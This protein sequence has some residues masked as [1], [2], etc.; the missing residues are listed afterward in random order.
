MLSL[1]CFISHIFIGCNST[2]APPSILSLTMNST[3]EPGKTLQLVVSDIGGVDKIKIVQL[4]IAPSLSEL[5]PCWIEYSTAMQQFRIR[6]DEGDAF[7][8]A[9]PGSESKVLANSKCTVD[10]TKAKATAAGSTLNISIPLQL[11]DSMQ[12]PQNIFAIAS[13]DRLHSGWKTVGVWAAR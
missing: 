11:G 3:N 13:G 12:L 8:G 4:M 10:L 7:I 1:V 2:V 5:R 6:N 9:A